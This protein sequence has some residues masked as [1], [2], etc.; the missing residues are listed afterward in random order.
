MADEPE[1]IEKEHA[2]TRRRRLLLVFIAAVL[3]ISAAAGVVIAVVFGPAHGHRRGQVN[4]HAVVVTAG[5]LVVVLAVMLTLFSW[6]L[7]SAK[8]S[9]PLAYPM[10]RRT[11]VSKALRT[12]RPIAR[13]DLPVAAAIVRTLQVRP[14]IVWVAVLLVAGEVV[15]AV[16]HTGIVRWAMLALAGLEAVTLALMVWLYRR[17]ARN[18][19]RAAASFDLT[20]GAGS[21]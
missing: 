17:F 14:W 5:I 6:R 16:L 18:Y 12:G 11:R 7:R 15:N 8:F 1:V 3:V 21:S 4:V 20:D 9:A 2:V 13:E 19:Q 10:R